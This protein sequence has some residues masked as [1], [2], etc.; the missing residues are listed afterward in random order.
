MGT[1]GMGRPLIGT[2]TKMNLTSSE[3]AEYLSALLG[4]TRDLAGVDVFV[5]P[6]FTSI[7]V[8]REL[9]ASSDIAWGAQDVHPDDPGA[10]TGDIAA[11]MLADL[12]CRFVECGHSE[13][14][15]DHA[16]TDEVIARKVR[17][18]VRH[19][20][21]PILCVGEPEP[22]GAA[23]ASAHVDRQLRTAL[24]ATDPGGI[25]ML[26]VAY[27][28]VWAIGTGARAADPAH[29]ERVHASLRA[30]AEHLL[31]DAH[32]VRVVYGG[33]VDPANAPDLLACPEVD[34]LFIGRSALDP[35]NLAAIARMAPQ[36]TSGER[37]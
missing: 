2:S 13:R 20:M 24:A 16:E 31:G 5:L 15:R 19:G 32:R 28:P 9:L 14:R 35:A 8:A 4:L 22:L 3:A 7:W 34:G 27:E 17:Q 26:V 36:T 10:H 37:S 6:P 18:I 25:G 29:V 11:S 30:T 33:S 21:T 12:G 1:Q 23:A